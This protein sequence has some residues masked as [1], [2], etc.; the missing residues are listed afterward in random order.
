MHFII[1]LLGLIA[2]ATFWLY[3]IK[4]GADAGR[5]VYDEVKG[6]VRRGQWSR[7]ADARLIETLSDPR[8]AAAILMVQIA[9]YDGEV[10]ASQKARIE[11]VMLDN[12][13][14]APDEAQGLYSFGRMAVGQI[15]DAANSLRH[16][17]RPIQ[18]KLDATEKADLI[19]MLHAIAEVEG[20]PNDRQ[21]QLVAAVN[22]ALLTQD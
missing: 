19:E 8:E 20:E 2:G 9:S 13:R 22:R 3:R 18:Q 5:E 7:K 6:A 11:A 17:L 10:T 12:F 4:R 14:C 16:I 21:R 1:A 15:N